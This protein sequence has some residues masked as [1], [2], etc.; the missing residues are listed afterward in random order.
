[1]HF[2]ED[3]NLTPEQEDELI[4]S[5]ARIILS[6]ALIALTHLEEPYNA[7]LSS[8]LERATASVRELANGF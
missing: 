3:S 7:G 5:N 6:A 4:A 1:M 2:S 8:L